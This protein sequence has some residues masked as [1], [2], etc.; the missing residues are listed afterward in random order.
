MAI[1]R[2]LEM[3]GV[4]LADAN[5]RSRP[6]RDGLHGCLGA[7]FGMRAR[8]LPAFRVSLRRSGGGTEGDRDRGGDD[9]GKDAVHLDGLPHLVAALLALV[10][11]YRLRALNRL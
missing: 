2:P 3:A 7:W 5:S 11:G 9:A 6:M 8:A 1:V 4:R 10:R